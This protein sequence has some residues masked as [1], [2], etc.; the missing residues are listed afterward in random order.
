MKLSK[1][2]NLWIKYARI[3]LRVAKYNL[4]TSTDFKAVA[5]FHAQ[6]CAEKVIKAYL[7][8]NKVRVHKTHDLEALVK[9]VSKVDPTFAKKLKKAK[10]LT[11]YAVTFRYPDAERRPLTLAL[12]KTS[13]KTAEYVFELCLEELRK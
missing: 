3:D 13:L 5:A 2:V 4:E 1:S 8:H 7:T 10:S 6:Q 11:A 9:D 12:A